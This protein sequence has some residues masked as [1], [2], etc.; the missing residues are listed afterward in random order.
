MRS[1]SFPGLTLGALPERAQLLRLVRAGTYDLVN[2]SGF[3]LRRVHGPGLPA[4]LQIAEYGF[5]DL[6]SETGSDEAWQAFKT[7][8]G[9]RIAEATNW[10]ANLLGSGQPVHCCCHQGRSRSPL[11]AAAGLMRAFGMS[12]QTAIHIITERHPEAAFTARSL[13]ML[14]TLAR[15]AMDHVESA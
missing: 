5:P 14:D 10:V 15:G 11:V 2:L 4:K 9:P 12:S 1:A 7:L 8:H 3:D 13:W 6:F